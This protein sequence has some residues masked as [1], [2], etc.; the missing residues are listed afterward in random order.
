MAIKLSAFTSDKNRKQKDSLD[1]A[2]EVRNSQSHRG[3]EAIF[4]DINDFK[5][6]L[7]ELGLPL[8]KDGEVVWTKIKDDEGLVKKYKSISNADY[9][10][11]RFQIWLKREPFDDV[12]SA[13]KDTAIQIK[14][15]LGK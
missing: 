10:K 12:I 7:L 3:K 5:K 14:E 11:Y 15:Y 8:T 9:W 6:Q 4:K 1:F 2:R 13:L